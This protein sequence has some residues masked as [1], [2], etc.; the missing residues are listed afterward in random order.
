[1]SHKLAEKAGFG[2]NMLGKDN[3]PTH[4]LGNSGVGGG[5]AV[6]SNVSSDTLDNTVQNIPMAHVIIILLFSSIFLSFFTLD[7][8]HHLQFF[9]F[10]CTIVI[11]KT[12]F[13]D[14]FTS[15]S[16]FLQRYV[17]NKYNIEVINPFKF[18]AKKIE[19]PS[20]IIQPDNSVPEIQ[21]EVD[22]VIFTNHFINVLLSFWI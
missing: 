22:E 20:C 10:I 1:V 2:K 7:I 11:Y 17:K 14:F 15:L 16:A 5:E 18:S 8:V 3:N 12:H 4:L 19:C 9:A 6:L 21:E 13:S